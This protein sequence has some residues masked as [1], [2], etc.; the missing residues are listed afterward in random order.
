MTPEWTICLKC[1]TSKKGECVLCPLK[2]R[3]KELEE[4]LQEIL[5]HPMATIDREPLLEMLN[6]IRLICRRALVGE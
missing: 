5:H 4:A 1:G 3:I 6:S 2:A